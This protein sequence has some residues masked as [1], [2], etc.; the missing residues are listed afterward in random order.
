MLPLTAQ[1]AA[2]AKGDSRNNKDAHNPGGN[3]GNI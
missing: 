1:N 3:C 2:Q